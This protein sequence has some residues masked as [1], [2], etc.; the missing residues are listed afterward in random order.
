MDKTKN[1]MVTLPNGIQIPRKQYEQEFEPNIKKKDPRGQ[2]LEQ[3][4][5]KSQA[6]IEREQKDKDARQRFEQQ[7]K[8]FKEET[9]D[10]ANKRIGA[11]MF[12][13]SITD[14]RVRKPE[15]QKAVLTMEERKERSKLIGKQKFKT[16]TQEE[17]ERLA[18]LN[19]R[20]ALYDEQQESNN[21]HNGMGM[22][23]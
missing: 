13:K 14:S 1:D 23:R 22:G 20:Q 15:T 3:T 10:K 8:K 12:E 9:S 2:A 17:L 4:I 19:Q 18:E 11:A 16:I 5:G 21:R 7:S 6:Q